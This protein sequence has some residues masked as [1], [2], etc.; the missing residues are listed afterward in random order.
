MSIEGAGGYKSL[1][2]DARR[3][4]T[5]RPL[6]TMTLITKNE[7]TNIAR[8][9]DSWWAFVDE[10]IVVDTGS[11]DGTLGECLKYARKRREEHKLKTKTVKWTDDFAAARQVADGLATGQWLAWC[12]LDDTIRGMKEL[13]RYAA[14]APDDVVAFFTRY[15]YAADSD[16][17]TISELWRERVVRNDGTPWTGRLH[18]HK[19]ITR[20]QV[21]Q[22]QPEIAEWVHHRNHEERTGERNLR[23]LEAWLADEPDSARVLH[24]LAM[25]HM[26]S[27]RPKDSSNMFER[28]LAC[29]G[30]MPDRR[31]QAVR[32]MCQMLMVQGRVEEAREHALRSL[33][34]VWNWADTHLTLAEAEQTLGRPDVAL[35]HAETAMQIGMPQTLLIINPL[36]YTAHPLALK[37]ICLA[38]MGRFEDAVRH[39]QEALAIA[40]SYQLAA[41]HLPLW[42]GQLKKQHAVGTILALADVLVEAGELVKARTMLDQAPW[43]IVDSEHL[44]RKRVELGREIDRRHDAGPEQAEDEAADAWLARHLETAVAA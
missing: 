26:G 32:L 22:V 18:E 43:Y 38:Q 27:E 39:G 25:E 37:A 4:M 2:R 30:E 21:V 24:S 42:Q 12:D 15:R 11:T 19:L 31:A 6:I 36:Q 10:V 17:N 9:F 5:D 28:Y 34:D 14:E 33:G 29:A 23:I 1:Q 35:T 3:R 8:C 13:R 20:G 40:P 7:R 44:V 41:Q 16:G